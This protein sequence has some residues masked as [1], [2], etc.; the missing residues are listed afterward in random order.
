MTLAKNAAV[1]SR[2]WTMFHRAALVVALCVAAT[3][4][5][6][7]SPAEC[8]GEDQTCSQDLQLASPDVLVQMRQSAEKVNID[9]GLMSD[10]TAQNENSKTADAT[11]PC[12]G[13][14]LHEIMDRAANGQGNETARYYACITLIELAYQHPE[15]FGINDSDGFEFNLKAVEALIQQDDSTGPKL[16]IPS[17]EK[18]LRR[19]NKQWKGCM[20]QPDAF[21]AIL[22]DE[23]LAILH[24]ETQAQL[25]QQNRQ[26]QNKSLP[27]WSCY[28][29]TFGEGTFVTEQI[30]D[31]S[32][33]CGDHIC[34]RYES[35]R[36]VES[37][38]AIQDNK[39][40]EVLFSSET[41]TQ[42]VLELYM[43]RFTGEVWSHEINHFMGSLTASKKERGAWGV[44]AFNGHWK[45]QWRVA[46]TSMWEDVPNCNQG[47]CHGQPLTPIQ[48]NN[49]LTQQL[50]LTKSITGIRVLTPTWHSQNSGGKLS[51]CVG[52]TP[53]DPNF[54]ALKS[55]CCDRKAYTTEVGVEASLFLTAGFSIVRGLGYSSGS[56]THRDGTFSS[57]DPTFSNGK[58]IAKHQLFWQ[59]CYEIGL[60]IGLDASVTHGYW[61][62]FEKIAGFSAGWEVGLSAV[63]GAGLGI[64]YGGFHGNDGVYGYTMSA[65][66][67]AGIDVS[68]NKCFA[69]G[70]GNPH[71]VSVNCNPSAAS[72]G[73]QVAIKAA[74]K[75]GLKGSVADAEKSVIVGS[76]IDEIGGW[77]G[78]W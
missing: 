10:S 65:S 2:H 4:I 22:V 62:D 16:D 15:Q 28:S 51:A 46:A 45:M 78:W 60:D 38:H 52:N 20:R 8:H 13:A 36:Y 58:C 54:G 32:A 37:T 30:Y 18:E 66:V 5:M 50:T 76:V 40:Q 67:G 11:D 72:V 33:R 34:Y 42:K 19:E 71:V 25:L 26:V 3:V 55:S 68:Y 64:V 6:G 47:S 69:T 17:L 31:P 24:G 29:A 49:V 27:F 70:I 77:F 53:P 59:Y 7:M 61:L 48:A 57:V 1:V 41:G 9:P 35:R 73:R 44:W 23:A 14:V 12:A 75:Y 21:C 43:E 56:G 74:Q 39:Y 63:V